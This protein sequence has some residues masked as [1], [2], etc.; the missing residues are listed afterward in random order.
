MNNKD[1][2]TIVI[3]GAGNLSWHLSLALHHAGLKILSIYNRNI[4]KAQKIANEVNTVAID[5]LSEI[6]SNADL[7]LLAVSDQAISELI[8]QLPHFNGIIA[9]TAG[10][11]P[12]ESISAGR[13]CIGVFYPFQTFTSGQTVEF[14]NVPLCIEASDTETGSKLTALAGKLSQKVVQL[15]SNQ[16]LQLHLAAVFVCNFANYF[17]TL[18]YNFLEKANIDFGLLHGLI[19]ETAR[20]A[21]QHQPFLG[22]TGPARRDDK[23]TI[24]KHLEIL[25]EQPD[26]QELYFELTNRILE[27][28]DHDK[29][30]SKSRNE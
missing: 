2:S 24:E 9:H 5:K 30:T 13:T 16:R 20:K 27:M 14:L 29:L 3:L 10:S 17:N 26:L 1:I 15:T 4:E 19:I 28:Y 12:L 6:P 18:A 11:V 21:T 25:N 7:Y 22:Q 23:I 8:D